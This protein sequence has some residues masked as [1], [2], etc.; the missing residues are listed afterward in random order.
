MQT[1]S[2]P[3]APTIT[4]VTDDVSPITG[5]VAHGGSTNDTSLVITGSA[6]AGAL[7]WKDASVG[8]TTVTVSQGEFASFLNISVHRTEI[9]IEARPR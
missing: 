7:V 8:M 2:A 1:T 6:E 3:D 5:A 4:A 9:L